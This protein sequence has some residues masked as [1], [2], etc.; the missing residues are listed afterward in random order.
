MILH[1]IHDSLPILFTKKVK[2]IKN[3]FKVYLYESKI[4]DTYF[5]IEG[6]LVIE[7]S[8]FELMEQGWR[9]E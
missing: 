1:T 4:S 2:F 6:G 7:I 5:L 8:L 9:T 3:I